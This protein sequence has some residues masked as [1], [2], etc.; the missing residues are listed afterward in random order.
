M[1]Y[2]RL[3]QR[4]KLEKSVTTARLNLQRAQEA[5]MLGTADKIEATQG[6]ILGF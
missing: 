6:Q 5:I 3:W 1:L 4:T 2:S